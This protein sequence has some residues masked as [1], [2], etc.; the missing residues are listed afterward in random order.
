VKPREQEPEPANSTGGRALAAGDLVA[1]ALV[2]VALVAFA[3]IRVQFVDVPWHL[4]TARLAR[5]LGH[6]PT[7]N[8]F[9][10]T[11]PAHP[12]YQQ[13]PLYQATLSAAHRLAGWEGL[14]ALCAA[15]W[16]LVFALFVRWAGGTRRAIALHLPWML[17]LWALERRMI[18]RPDLFTMLALGAMLCAYD[19]YARGRRWAIALVPLLHLAWVNSHQLFP[20]SLAVQGLFVGHLLLARWSAARAASG[21]ATLGLDAADARVPVLPAVAALL[22]ST[23]L[24]FAT[25]LG[26]DILGV[27]AH[28]AGSLSRMRDQVG[29][30]TPIWQ[31]PLELGL[32]LVTGVPAAVALVLGRRRWSP[33]DVGVWLLSLALVLAAVR[34]LMFFGIV[35]IAVLQRAI[36]R[37]READRAR[38]PL[39]RPQAARLVR[40]IGVVA[41]VL[42][43]TT[44]ITHRWVR[45]PLILGGTQ[46]GLGRSYGGWADAA[47][48]FVRQAP[49]PG[50][51]MN[52]AWTSGNTL[53]WDVPEVPV[54]VDPR[55]ETY[56]HD[57]LREV[58]DAYLDDAKTAALIDR[59]NVTW[60]Y[61]EH[62]RQH[63][64]ARALTLLRAGWEPVYVDSDHLILVRPVPEM[65]AYRAAHRIDLRRAPLLDLLPAGNLAPL[66][67][68]QR[69]RF[70]TL[71]NELG[72][73]AR[74]DEQRRLAVAE[75]G[76]EAAAAAFATH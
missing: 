53:V 66:R 34:G 41:T 56:P 18:L 51:M 30:F 69:A 73:P 47:N 36:S 62:F 54:F 75:S 15:G 14:S 22:A 4:A 63:I 2:V 24:C 59:W 9:S 57:F 52:M 43:A 5:A 12:I 74:A 38:P 17:G 58:A 71:M 27:T 72:E 50:H 13:Y 67:A 26:T 48:A 64:R 32:A 3:V 37:G 76:D 68:Q 1:A 29:E 10:Y 16:A 31:M 11:F 55:F 39:M 70:A 49:P 44:V 45:P 42:L 60:V 21:A 61:A 46:P 25:P 33:F 23:A 35:S 28:T 40:W 65:A 20:V 19:A 7:L 6:W 8:T